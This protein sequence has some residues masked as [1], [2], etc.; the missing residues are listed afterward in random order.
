MTLAHSQPGHLMLVHHARKAESSDPMDMALGSVAFTGAVDA[1]LTLTREAEGV[2]HFAAY[3]RDNV[4]VPPSILALDPETGMVELRGTK[5]GQALSELEG[6]LEDYVTANTGATH[7]AILGAV[8]GKRDR[9]RDALNGLV[10]KGRLLRDGAGLNGK[11]FR[12]YPPI[13]ATRSHPFP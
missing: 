9:K 6:A 3:G 7:A 10:D 2:R 8:T 4:D 13:E 1:T 5:E 11:P 12:Y